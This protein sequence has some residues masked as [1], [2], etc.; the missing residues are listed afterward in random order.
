ML[1]QIQCAK[2]RDD[3]LGNK[4]N[5]LQS[6]YS[7]AVLKKKHD[8]LLSMLDEGMINIMETLSEAI[9]EYS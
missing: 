3:L 1:L 4:G 8:M 6:F 5:N 9:L 2:I 7:L